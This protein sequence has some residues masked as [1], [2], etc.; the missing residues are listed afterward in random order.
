[1]NEL[2]KKL[3]EEAGLT[4]EQAAKALNVIKEFI[5]AKV[6]PMMHP[7]IENFLASKG[8]GNDPLSDMMKNFGG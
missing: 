6:P 2:V 5:Q 8:E 7:M 1:M 3:T 4:E